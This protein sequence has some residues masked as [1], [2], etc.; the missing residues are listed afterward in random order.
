MYGL[1]YLT[2]CPTAKG[3]DKFQTENEGKGF[4]GCVGAI[5]WSKCFKKIFPMQYKGLYLDTKELKL[6]SI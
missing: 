5:D 1:T 4:P 3:L 6:E 2:R